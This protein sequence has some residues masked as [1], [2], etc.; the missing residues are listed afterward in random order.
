M[1]YILFVFFVG[2]ISYSAGKVSR[3]HEEY[4]EF[5][6]CQEKTSKELMSSDKLKRWYR[7]IPF[8]M[9][10]QYTLG[11]AYDCVLNRGYK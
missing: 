9:A 7:Q 2:C 8:E 11:R 3:I 10:Y 6:T 5:T 1:K 4:K